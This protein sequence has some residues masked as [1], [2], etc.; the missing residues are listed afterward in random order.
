M[1]GYKV[2][3]DLVLIINDRDYYHS[4]GLMMQDAN[5]TDCGRKVKDSKT[6][7]LQMAVERDFYPCPNCYPFCYNV[8]GRK[9]AG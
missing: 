2:L 9:I 4:L 1:S 5:Y 7:R 8:F 6:V 3:P